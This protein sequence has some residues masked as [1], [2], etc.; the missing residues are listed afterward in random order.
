MLSKIKNRFNNL[1]LPIAVKLTILYS[2]VLFCMLIFSG[3]LAV[4]G[5]Y[6]MLVKQAE[7]NIDSSA[8][9]VV[10]YLNDG[11]DIDA[12]LLQQN[13]LD[14]SV[15]L[16]IYGSDEQLLLDSE[17]YISGDRMLRPH[18]DEILESYS[19]DT[20]YDQPVNLR[21]GR[22]EKDEF[23][24][25]WDRH[26]PGNAIVKTVS[27]SNEQSYYLEFGHN[28]DQQYSFLHKLAFSLLLASL[29]ALFIAVWSGSFLSRRILGPI[30]DITSAA[31]EIEIHNLDK[32][33]DIKG[34]DDELRE[35]SVT[36]NH[37]LDRIQAG[38]ERQRRFISDASHE[39]RTPVTVI[40]GYADML[41]R[42]GKQDES[43][44]IEGLDAIKSET[45]TMHS[46]IEKLLF[47]ARADKGQ[48][49]LLLGPVAMEQLI[50]EI[51]RDTALIAPG[52]QV[53][54]E[55]NDPVMIEA[56]EAQLKQMLRI[57]ID[58]SIKYTPEGGS[59]TISSTVNNGMLEIEIKDSGI[60]I[61]E[62]D[63]PRIFDRFYRVDESRTRATGG[64]GL[65]LSI[66]RFI[67]SLHGFDID[68]D[69]RLEEG[70]S[71]R[72]LIPINS[73]Q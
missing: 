35:L 12:E 37:M 25:A 62:N 39:L 53:S 33:I 40:S 46:L 49:P 32:R 68:I 22:K 15:S 6:Y 47:L 1:R 57:F 72:V 59:I 10:A 51:V 66:A 3:V 7:A 45:A 20:P 67:A 21:D 69:S 54:L 19:P 18:S 17:P 43:A 73:D 11:H 30:R 42:W 58:N 13:L 64:S 16:R 28:M 36:L 4:S 41:D 29:A 71:V 24:T 14:S 31:T 63:L 2:A 27:W 23:E 44:L 8:S 38:V 70:T 61:S 65:G 34:G 60:G 9:K 48:Q 5:T 26:G 52:H 56:D 55:A 50:E